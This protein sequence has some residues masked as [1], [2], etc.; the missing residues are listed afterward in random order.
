VQFCFADHV[1]GGCERGKPGHG[2]EPPFQRSPLF[3]HSGVDL[4]QRI[5]EAKIAAAVVLEV[6]PGFTVN[7]LASGNIT[8]PERM[9]MLT[10][11][12]RKAGLP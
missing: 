1:H 6:Q 5:E 12:L 10:D 4:P 8:T 7:G 3:A 11:A 2:S 9:E